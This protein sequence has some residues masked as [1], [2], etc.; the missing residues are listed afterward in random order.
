MMS[1]T[2][3]R[4][5]YYHAWSLA[6]AINNNS[7]LG[8]N[9]YESDGN[10][11]WNMITNINVISFEVGH[12]SMTTFSGKS[13]KIIFFSF[14]FFS[15]FIHRFKLATNLRDAISNWNM[16]TNQWLRL[17]VYERVPKKYGT[18]LTF[19]LSALWHGFYPGYY[20]TFISGALIVTAGRTVCITLDWHRA[21]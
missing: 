21:H 2:I 1:T 11:K 7:G 20:L 15:I 4:F 3:I 8:F 14:F 10:P 18:L 13:R 17:I 5:K 16:G 12:D 9:G 6:D 19:S